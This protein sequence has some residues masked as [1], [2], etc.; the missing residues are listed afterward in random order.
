MPGLLSQRPDRPLP[1]DR[2]QEWGHYGFSSSLFTADYEEFLERL[3]FHCLKHTEMH[4]FL[5]VPLWIRRLPQEVL[6]TRPRQRSSSNS[7]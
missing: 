6:Q 3:Q 4:K 1:Q 2:E 7:C 5:Q